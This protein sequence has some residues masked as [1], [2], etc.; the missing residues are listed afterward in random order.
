M[1][2]HNCYSIDRVD[3]PTKLFVSDGGYLENLAMLEVLKR[4]QKR[5]VSYDGGAGFTA[6]SLAKLIHACHP[7]TPRNSLN[8]IGVELVNSLE[9]RA[10]PML[11]M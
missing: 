11:K 1:H 9:E 10:P 4:Q 2:R 8:T 3:V 6:D 7:K 5:I